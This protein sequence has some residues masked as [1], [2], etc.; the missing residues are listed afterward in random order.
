MTLCQAQEKERLCRKHFSWPRNTAIILIKG[1]SRDEHAGETGV[2]EGRVGE[3]Q[4]RYVGGTVS[5]QVQRRRAGDAGEEDQSQGE[6]RLEWGA[7]W[8]SVVVP[9]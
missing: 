3:A 9:V 4:S 6:E 8:M 1:E 2:T 5:E 7:A